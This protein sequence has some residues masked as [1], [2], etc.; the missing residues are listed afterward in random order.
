MR[1][2]HQKRKKG[3]KKGK[4]K[5]GGGGKK[6][7]TL[8]KCPLLIS[9][10]RP[11]NGRKE[12][13]RERKR[14]PRMELPPTQTRRRQLSKR[15]KKKAIKKGKKKR[16]SSLSPLHSLYPRYRENERGGEKESGGERKKRGEEGAIFPSNSLCVNSSPAD[17]GKGKEKEEKTRPAWHLGAVKRE[18]RRRVREKK[19]E[20]KH[21]ASRLQ[22]YLYLRAPK[23]KENPKGRRAGSAYYSSNLIRPYDTRKRE[24]LRKG[25]RKRTEGVALSF[26]TNTTSRKKKKK[27]KALKRKGKKKNREPLPSGETRRRKK[28]TGRKRE[29]KRKGRK[30]ER[31]P[32]FN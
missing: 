20:R 22:F 4:E 9:A 18:K 1:P 23:G 26:R 2:G 7:V 31:P 15:K 14:I 30:N 11:V 19:K 3:S 8:R 17:E 6:V 27:K 12:D 21:P 5:R 32:G 16:N 24:D 13:G 28:K 10:V 29:G 25:E